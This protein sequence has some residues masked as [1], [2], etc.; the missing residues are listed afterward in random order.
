M[1]YTLP[2]I[3]DIQDIDGNQSD[4]REFLILR[5]NYCIKLGASYVFCEHRY[6]QWNLNANSLKPKKRNSIKLYRYLFIQTNGKCKE[7]VHNS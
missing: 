6:T 1:K 4:V 5:H 2:T 7:D 3:L